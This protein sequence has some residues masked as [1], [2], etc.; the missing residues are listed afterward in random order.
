[1]R[2]SISSM[3]QLI[4]VLENSTSISLFIP[5]FPGGYRERPLFDDMRALNSDI[6]TVVYPGTTANDGILCP[7]SVVN[8]IES[9]IKTLQKISK[10]LYIFAYSFGTLFLIKSKINV[11][12]IVGVF[13]F[14]PIFDL[15]FCLTGLFADELNQLDQ[16]LFTVDTASFISKHTS[17][18]AAWN[19][20]IVS[21]QNWIHPTIRLIF[22]IGK[23]DT[24]VNQQHVFSLLEQYFNRLSTN[25]YPLYLCDG[26]HKL[27]SIYQSNEQLHN[28]LKTM[29]T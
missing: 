7:D 25:N 22:A 5:G 1:M 20:Y 17:E 15:K 13:L 9:A 28:I 21:L 4:E 12:N 23:Y 11:E 6:Y 19:E 18:N 2:F 24:V 8:S 27:D 10:P 26:D 16:S 3:L 29:R 14:S